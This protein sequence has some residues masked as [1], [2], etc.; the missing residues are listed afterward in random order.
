MRRA[1]AAGLGTCAVIACLAAVA[2]V[3][4]SSRTAAAAPVAHRASMTKI[5]FMA[6]YPRPPWVAQIPWV[7]AMNKGW[8]K[9]AGLDIH[10]VFPS[11]P[12]DPARFIGI[13]Q[14]DITV[15][16]TPDLL[17]AASKGLKVSALASVFDRNVEGIM[18]WKDSGITTPKQ[19]E[20]HT[21]AIY[22]FP[23]ANL[24][25]QTFSQHYGIDSSKVKKVSEGNYGVPL[26]VSNKVDAIDAAAPSELV[27]AELQAKKPARFWVY[28]KQ[29]GIPNFYWFVIAGNSDWVKK[30]P[31]AAKTFVNVTMK[32]VRWSFL[33]QKEAVNIFVQTYKKDVSPQLAKAA[34]AQ[35]VKYDSTRF[36]KNQPPGWMDPKIWASYQNFLLQKKFLSKGVALNTLLTG[37]QYVGK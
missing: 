21:V 25:W 30:N 2:A 13:G 36:V 6:D 23:M 12:S 3:G 28:L 27:D 4:A 29:N 5:T 37:N 31:A 26:I 33:H 35:I 19:L 20:G 1:V 11:T 15:S 22:D 18:V 24:N 34:W 10:Y 8:Y 17:T 32:A 16:Y 14:A 7:V 9:Q